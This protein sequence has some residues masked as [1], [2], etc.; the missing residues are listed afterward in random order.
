MAHRVAHEV[1]EKYHRARLEFATQVADMASKPHYLE[2]LLDEDAIVQLR[3]LLADKVS[4]W[5]QNTHVT[6][7][8][9]ERLVCWVAVVIIVQSY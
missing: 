3:R 4:T 6:L 8:L 5:F 1:F 2:S 7:L 9:C